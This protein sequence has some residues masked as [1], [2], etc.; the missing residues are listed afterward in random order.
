VKP[1]LKLILVALMA[2]ALWRIGSAYTA[3]YRFTDSVHSAAMDQGRTEEDLRQKVV[4]L[5]STYDVPVAEDSIAIRRDQHHTFVET[6][7]VAPVALLPGYV[8]KWPFS[9]NVDA[10]VIVPPRRVEDLARP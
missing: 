10:F 3:F 2:N 8:Y 4:E 9:V 6:S 1:L 5:A 7:Y